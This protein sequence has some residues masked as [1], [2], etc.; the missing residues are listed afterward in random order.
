MGA[1]YVQSSVLGQ[2]WS[3]FARAA[4][5]LLPQV[6]LLTK[7]KEVFVMK[8]RNWKFTSLMLVAAFSMPVWG[9]TKT[10]TL[11]CPV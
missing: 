8:D 6:F 10:V 3:D 4:V 9:V 7:K 2:L 1:S 5:S 11:D